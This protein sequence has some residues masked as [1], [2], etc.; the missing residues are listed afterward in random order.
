[1]LGRLVELDLRPDLW[2]LQNRVWSMRPLPE[3]ARWIARLLGF[4]EGAV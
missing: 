3:P 1:M 4:A 2:R